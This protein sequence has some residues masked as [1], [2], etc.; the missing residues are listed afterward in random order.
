M[1][2]IHRG[3]LIKEGGQGHQYKNEKKRWFVLKDLFLFY[4]SAPPVRSSPERH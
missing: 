2:T 3:F 1:D 4:Y